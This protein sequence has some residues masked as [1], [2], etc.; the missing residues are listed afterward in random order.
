MVS[1]LKSK[2]IFLIIKSVTTLQ[3]VVGMD[4]L[5]SKKRYCLQKRVTGLRKVIKVNAKGVKKV[6]FN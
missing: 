2:T 5:D 1:Q 6:K 3:K 4:L